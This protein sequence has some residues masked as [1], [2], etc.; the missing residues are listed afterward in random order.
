MSTVL[1]V[2][3][4]L[5]A[6]I[7]MGIGV[8]LRLGYN[9]WES[10]SF[11]IP[12]VFVTVFLFSSTILDVYET[13]RGG[14][15]A[16]EC[17]VRIAVSLFISFILVSAVFY[18]LPSVVVG[19]G[20]LLLTI[21]S[22]GVLQS[23]WHL[24]FNSYIN[25]PGLVRRVLIVGTDPLANQVGKIIS[26]THNHVLAGY[27]KYSDEPLH[28]PSDLVVSKRGKFLDAVKQLRPHKIILSVSE[29]AKHPP[30][31]DLIAC[32]LSGVEVIDAPS[33]YEQITGRLLI[34]GIPPWLLLFSDGFRI[35][36]IKKFS[37]RLTDVIFSVVG[38]AILAPFSLIIA[39]IIKMDSPVVVFYKQK[40]LGEGGK[41]F[42]MYK[43]RTM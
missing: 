7:S 38:I 8:S 21:L 37:K 41:I 26:T 20:V 28:V 12:A 9:S 5:L 29:K 27:V 25:F 42:V 30:I 43:I 18:A 33:F 24:A 34:E 13:R 32:K 40:R 39:L 36:A 16:K 4:G 11:P 10:F 15:Q 22:F 19:R 3:D 17:L 14:Y 23:L 31:K 6:L 35:P 1:L 2:V